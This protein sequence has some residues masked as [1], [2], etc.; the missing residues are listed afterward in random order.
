[1]GNTSFK[2]IFSH[3]SKSKHA[4]LTILCNLLLFSRQLSTDF[5]VL[6]VIEPQSTNI[7]FA[8]SF[9]FGADN[10]LSNSKSYFP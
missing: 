7:V 6:T 8:A 2:S 4:D 9:I 5:S 3:L 10:S 1:M